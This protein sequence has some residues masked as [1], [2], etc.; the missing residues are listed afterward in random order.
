MQSKWQ[1]CRDLSFGFC[2]VFIMPIIIYFMHVSLAL[3]AHI[4]T[5][6]SAFVMSASLSFSLSQQYL[7]CGRARDERELPMHQRNERRE[8]E[9]V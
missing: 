6:L 8:R 1:K 9:S 2:I 5:V 3:F 7:N 4:V